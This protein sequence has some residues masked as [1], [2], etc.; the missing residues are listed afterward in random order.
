M[1]ETSSIG[2]GAVAIAAAAGLSRLLGFV[3]DMV[4]A[5][6]LG[7]GPMADAF[8]AAFRLPNALRRFFAE[9]SA[10]LAL[11][12][13]LIE[14]GKNHGPER[15]AETARGVLA[16]LVILLGAF[17]LW[18][19]IW[20]SSLVRL[21]APGFAADPGQTA[22]TAHLLRLC[23][24]YVLLVAA[25]AWCMAVLNA[26]NRF[27][28]PAL[29]PGILNIALIA[30]AL[31]AWRLGWPMAE[32]LASAVILSGV[33]Q[34]LV[35]LPALRNS[36]FRWRGRWDLGSA[37]PVLG[38]MGPCIL[39]V[40]SNQLAMLLV[41]ILATRLPAGRVSAIYY[42]DRLA[43]LP[44][45][46]ATALGA[47]ALPAF[48]L[49]ASQGRKE[50][51]HRRVLDC[52]RTSLFLSL[53]AA[54][55]LAALARPIVEI[56]FGRG[57]F[58]AQAVDLTTGALVLLSLG[59]PG[60]NLLRQL[61]AFHSSEGR[62][63]EAALAAL[64]SIVLCLAIGLALAPGLGHLGLA[65]AASAAGWA[66]ALALLWRPG[67]TMGWLGPVCASALRLGGASLIMA[68]CVRSGW[69][70]L[71]HELWALALVI[72]LGLAVYLLTARF[73][74]KEEWRNAR[75]LLLDR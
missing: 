75:D 6:L 25:A 74:G 48:S 51:L 26:Q 16:T 46:F 15:A 13:E 64:G 28:T 8:I 44:L 19:E 36:G 66:N 68:L 42:A 31:A 4:L 49:L 12:P 29:A 21:L 3:R 50:E 30:A 61:L 67:R 73:L 40:S 24:P 58:D 38:R 71:P 53:P 20:T 57:E 45:V 59:I 72:F 10:S 65:L 2:R 14:A 39:A 1:V 9:G 54:A 52:L 23:L 69:E 27:L 33:L 43:Q 70:R 11:T 47:A 55:G 35:Q 7:A 17:V 22:L 41:T 34:V 18:G 62:I 63:R 37:R 60:Q 5:S 56:L 32:A